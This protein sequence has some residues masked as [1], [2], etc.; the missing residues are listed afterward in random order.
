M[1]IVKKPDERK[2][3]LLNIALKLFLTRGYEGTS[4]KDIYTEA[5]GSFGMFYH[6]FE[7][8]E[9]IFQEA[10]SNYVHGFVKNFADILLDTSLAYKKRYACV[11]KLY[12]D[13]LNGRDS[14]SGYKRTSVEMNVFR[15]LSLAVVNELVVIIQEYIEEGRDAGLLSFDDSETT[16]TFLIYGIWGMIRRQGMNDKHNKNAVALMQKLAPFFAELLGAESSLFTIN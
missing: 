13:F 7:S 16:A 8:K 1:R 10:M 5:K 6:H 4:V 3:E 15:R 2:E 12:I 11:I 14:I 9:A